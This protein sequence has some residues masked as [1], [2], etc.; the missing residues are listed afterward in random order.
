M[1]SQI[2]H[3]IGTQLSI[4]RWT[5]C[6]LV[7]STGVV[8]KV[9]ILSDQPRLAW[10]DQAKPIAQRVDSL[11]KSKGQSVKEFTKPHTA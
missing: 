4:S 6:S 8:E 9:G 11:E 5:P 1:A 10:I 2:P 3:R 7:A